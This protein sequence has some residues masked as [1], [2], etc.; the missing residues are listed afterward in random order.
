MTA[1]HGSPHSA[2]RDLHQRF[3]WGC[4]FLF[5]DNGAV[6]SRIS[7]SRTEM[8]SSAP[9]EISTGE[10]GDFSG[11]PALLVEPHG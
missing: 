10:R 7:N 6:S 1:G 9:G 5:V 8:F 4:L 2:K 11:S 3:W